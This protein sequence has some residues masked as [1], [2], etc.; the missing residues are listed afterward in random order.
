MRIAL[1]RSGG[2]TGTRVR[3]ELD[4]AGLPAGEEQRLRD[5]LAAA[6]LKASRSPAVRDAFTYD[7]AIEDGGRLS[8]CRTDDSAMND[9]TRELVD[10]LLEHAP[11]V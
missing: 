4:T 10:W 8:T 11:R 5:L 6:E 2:F 1:T 9:H 3:V 7:L